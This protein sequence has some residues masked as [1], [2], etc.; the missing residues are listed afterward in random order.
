MNLRHL[1]GQMRNSYPGFERH[2][3]SILSQ[4][5]RL[6]YNFSSL[7]A[8]AFGL[9]SDALRRFYDIDRNMQHRGK[10]VRYPVINQGDS[11]GQGVGPHYDAGFL[12]FVSLFSFWTWLVLMAF[13]IAPASIL[14]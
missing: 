2:L 6:S 10:V 7:L 11:E 8:E 4:V 13:F 9:S 1:S 5:Q 14:S 12:T 3:R